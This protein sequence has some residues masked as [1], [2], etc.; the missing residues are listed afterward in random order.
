MIL[1]RDTK[2]ESVPI[3][4]PPFLVGLALRLNS[5]D[6]FTGSPKLV[7]TCTHRSSHNSIIR[8]S[9]ALV[10]SMSGNPCWASHFLT[11]ATC[12]GAEARAVKIFTVFPSAIHFFTRFNIGLMGLPIS[13]KLLFPRSCASV[14]SR[15]TPIHGAPPYRTC[16]LSVYFWPHLRHTLMKRPSSAQKGRNSSPQ[17]A[18]PV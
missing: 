2:P 9:F 8:K 18:S 7:V 16:V 5:T 13:S 15:S 6:W 11:A 1:K 3:R 10:T 17:Q 14:P 4:P 12:L